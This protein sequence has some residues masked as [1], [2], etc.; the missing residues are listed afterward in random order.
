[1][2]APTLIP[3]GGGEIIG[4][5][6]DRR[7][8]VLSDHDALHATWSRFGPRRDGANLH[9]HRLHTD[10]FYV[11]EGELTVRVGVEDD[12]RVVPAGQLVSVPPLVVHGFRNASEADV[13][14]LN[15]HAPGAGFIQ[16]MRGIRD[17][18]RVDMDQEDPPSEGIRP[19]SEARIGDASVVFDAI[20]IEEV[21]CEPGAAEGPPRV[22]DRHLVWYYVL[23]GELALT[24]GPHEVHA[25]TGS[26]IKLPPGAPHAAAA[27]G[28]EPVRFLEIGV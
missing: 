24:A 27:A 4:D 16:Y 10:F 17:G 26:W 20:A 28:P 22:G 13:K 3:P 8:E 11:L 21:R 25:H 7:V 1:M 5:A 6:P 12:N 18:A 19:A 15:L 14:Y 2:S 23:E 9:I